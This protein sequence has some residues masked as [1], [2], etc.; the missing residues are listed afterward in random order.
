MVSYLERTPSI[1]I[2]LVV[3]RPSSMAGQPGQII[4]VDAVPLVCRPTSERY[5]HAGRTAITQ[6]PRQAVIDKH[7]LAPTPI[8]LQ[9]TFGFE[10][11]QVGNQMLSGWERLRYFRDQIFNLYHQ[12]NAQDMTDAVT[13]VQSGNGIIDPSMYHSL[14]PGGNALNTRFQEGDILFANL[15]D[16]YFEFSARVNLDSFVVSEAAPTTTHLPQYTLTL[17]ACGPAIV[18]TG[19]MDASLSINLAMASINQGI[20]DTMGSAISLLSTPFT[21]LNQGATILSNATGMAQADLAQVA[22]AMGMDRQSVQ[23]LQ[24]AVQGVAGLGNMF[25][26]ILDVAEGRTPRQMPN[27]SANPNTSSVGFLGLAMQE[28][29]AMPDIPGLPSIHYWDIDNL[30]QALQALYPGQDPAYKQFMIDWQMG[31]SLGFIQLSTIP[32]FET[33]VIDTDRLIDTSVQELHIKM[34]ILESWIEVAAR[35]GDPTWSQNPPL[36]TLQMIQVFNYATNVGEMIRHANRYAQMSEDQYQNMLDSAAQGLP[37]GT[38][39]RELNHV[40][41]VREDASDIA[42]TY[43]ITTQALA[44]ANPGL[45]LSGI[46]AGDTV[47]IPLQLPISQVVSHQVYGDQSGINVLGTDLPDTMQWDDE[48]NDFLILTPQQTIVQGVGNIFNTRP[49][50]NPIDR[51][52]GLDLG[53]G[54][55]WS[56]VGSEALLRQRL[57]SAVEADDRVLS[58]MGIK[59]GRIEQGYNLTA[60]VLLKQSQSLL[61]YSALVHR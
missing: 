35:I 56:A 28:R 12:I 7:G 13:G 11:R 47:V 29:R 18:P 9:G 25:S 6:L 31:A 17:T 38:V 30:R 15:W 33:Q 2:Q 39:A 32:D 26:T 22:D 58:V 61:G 24:Q 36:H 19:A 46:I 57:K 27:P 60:D 16:L 5:A 14:L 37:T 49:G 41:G 4:E 43:G 23:N 1:V 3:Y 20:S 59:I 55:T 42:A 53:F 10:A 52:Y 45:I 54:E 21:L 44:H 8:T 40:V 51:T 48:R 34:Q 50:E